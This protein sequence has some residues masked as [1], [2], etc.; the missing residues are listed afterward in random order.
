MKKWVLLMLC[1]LLL[2]GCSVP[3]HP[4]FTT[5]EE[6]TEEV[7][8][9]TTEETAEE[10]TAY[11]ETQPLHSELL[12]PGVTAD[13][14]VTYFNEVCLNAEMV[15]GGNATLIQ[16]W[17][18]PI[19]YYIFGEPTSEDLAALQDFEAWVNTVPGFPGMHPTQDLGAAN[20][21]IYFCTEQELHNIMGP[22]FE[23]LDGAVTYWYNNNAIYDA[24]IC[25]RTDLNQHLRNSVIKEELYNGLGPI[26][27]TLLRDDSI[28]YAN[29]AEPQH[30]TEIDKLIMTLLYD[31]AILCGMNAEDCAQIIR[32][33]YY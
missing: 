6:I 7:T 22:G 16:K 1:V 18:I 24:T 11:Q 8:E 26:N 4:M 30:L 19:Y 25:I 31:P 5:T 27:D 17:D 33:I 12:I 21:K 13:D 3:E 14:V 23:G 10:T 9:E 28:I 29:F 15:N 2:T 20:M 32:S